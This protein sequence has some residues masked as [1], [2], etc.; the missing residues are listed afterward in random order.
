MLCYY[1]GEQIMANLY[2]KYEA[3]TLCALSYKLDHSEQHEHNWND[4]GGG[5]TLKHCIYL[6][7]IW[8]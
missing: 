5:G 2:M 3:C 1:C 8:P 4:E 7:N 6:G